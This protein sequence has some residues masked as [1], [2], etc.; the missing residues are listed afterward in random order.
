MDTLQQLVRAN[1]GTATVQRY[2]TAARTEIR[3]AATT[4]AG[5]LPLES[6][7]VSVDTGMHRSNL[8]QTA[9]GVAIV[10]DQCR[11]TGVSLAQS[12]AGTPPS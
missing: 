3:A 11:R 9:L 1:A 6:G 7:I 2:L 8:G 4:D 12:P 5:W 10:R